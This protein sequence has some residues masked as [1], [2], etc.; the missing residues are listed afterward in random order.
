MSDL[1]LELREMPAIQIA[2]KIARAGSKFAGMDFH[3]A[4]LT[5]ERAA[6]PVPGSSGGRFNG[7]AFE[8]ES[9]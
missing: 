7:C 3:R 4:F 8:R 6:D 2:D 1:Q 5:E 9:P